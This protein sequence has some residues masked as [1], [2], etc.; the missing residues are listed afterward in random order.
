MSGI[1]IILAKQVEMIHRI[2]QFFGLHTARSA[3]S[4]E[5]SVLQKQTRSSTESINSAKNALCRFRDEQYPKYVVLIRKMHRNNFLLLDLLKHLQKTDKTDHRKA[6]V[7]QKLNTDH[8]HPNVHTVDKMFLA[9]YQKSPF[10]TKMKP[11]CLSFLDFNDSISPEEFEQIPKYMRGR[12]S[13]DELVGFLQ[14]VVISSFEEKYS[15]LYKN[16]KAVTNQQDLVLWKAYNQQ[17][18]NFP[19][20]K[21]ITQGDIARKMGRLIDKKVN[22]KL[23]ML[24]HL[25]ILQETRHEGTVYYFWIRE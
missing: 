25:H 5:I 16:K 1:E 10:V 6:L 3:I 23:T 2:E 12:E 22:A 13:L 14:T 18:S 7:E 8:A 19:N 24:R 15:L 20:S 4:V 11:R 21:F 9:D 17:Q